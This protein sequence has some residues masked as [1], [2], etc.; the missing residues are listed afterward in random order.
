MTDMTY[1][2]SL[3][4]QLQDALDD[5]R[6]LREKISELTPSEDDWVPL[7]ER[8]PETEDYDEFFEIFAWDAMHEQVIKVLPRTLH[9]RKGLTHWARTRCKAP[10]TTTLRLRPPSGGA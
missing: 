3:Y 6:A 9:K 8:S 7:E 4:N 1:A 5:N 2:D 10:P